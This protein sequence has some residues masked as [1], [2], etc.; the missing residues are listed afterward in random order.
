MC[1]DMLV[2]SDLKKGQK[3]YKI[4]VDEVIPHKVIKFGYSQFRQQFYIELINMVTHQPI[5]ISP[6]NNNFYKKKVRC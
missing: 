6:Q 3:V 1:D 4:T 2:F 5:I